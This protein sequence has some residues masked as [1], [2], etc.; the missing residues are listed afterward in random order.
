MNYH[1]FM[2]PSFEYPPTTYSQRETILGDSLI[3]VSSPSNSP[4]F[5]VLQI[6]STEVGW[7]PN[8]IASFALRRTLLL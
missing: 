8:R 4:R 3:G 5:N 2:S 1:L 6:G 7:L